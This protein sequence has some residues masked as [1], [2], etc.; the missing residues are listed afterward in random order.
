MRLPTGCLVFDAYGA[1]ELF[2]S[3]MWPRHWMISYGLPMGHILVRHQKLH[4][5]AASCGQGIWVISYGLPTGHRVG[6]L[7][8]RWC[9]VASSAGHPTTLAYSR[10]E[11]CCACSRCGTGGLFFNFFISSILTSFSNASSLVRWLDILKY[12]GLGL[13]NPMVVVSY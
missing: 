12:C 2:G 10:A 4:G 11:A 5:H 9:W 3:F 13:Y 6:G 1:C 7:V 8:G